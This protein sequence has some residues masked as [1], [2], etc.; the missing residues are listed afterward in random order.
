VVA[1]ELAPSDCTALAVMTRFFVVSNA[2]KIISGETRR[3]QPTGIPVARSAACGPNLLQSAGE[4]KHT[5]DKKK[6]PVGD[7][8]FCGGGRYYIEAST[9][10][11]QCLPD[12]GYRCERC[13]YWLCVCRVIPAERTPAEPRS[14][15]ARRASELCPDPSGAF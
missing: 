1:R 12:S 13:D 15:A 3:Q 10:L 7:E 11:L 8:L 4:R 14:L 5:Q 9:R 2:S 6:V